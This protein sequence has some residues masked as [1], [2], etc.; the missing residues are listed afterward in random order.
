MNV[1]F[2]VRVSTAAQDF[3][4]QINELTAFAALNKWNVASVF[5]EK[6]SGTKALSERPELM[7]LIAYVKDNNIDKVMVTEISR[8][9]RNTN[10]LLNVIE[11]LNANRIS[12]FIKSNSIETLDANGNVNIL[13]KFMLTL[14]SEI[15]VMEKG[16]IRQR[17][18]SGY[19][20]YISSGGKVGRRVGSKKNDEQ[21]LLEYQGVAKLIRKDY[22]LRKIAALEQ[23]SVN[24]VAK[25]K[26][27]LQTA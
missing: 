11:L 12:L 23:V 17:M 8:L 19:N 15:A 25:V 3:N 7:R 1:V 21:Y 27:L 10:E 14:L 22:P 16:T 2:L 18:Q 13:A 4:Y 24:T 5:T 26:R 9:A 6:I 20:H